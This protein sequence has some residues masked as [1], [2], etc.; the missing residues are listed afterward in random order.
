MREETFTA[1]FV[2]AGPDPSGAGVWK[3]SHF[4]F[5]VAAG[6]PPL[7]PCPLSPTLSAKGT[8]TWNA[9]PHFLPKYPVKPRQV[10][11][12]VYIHKPCS[13]HLSLL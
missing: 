10:E 6:L 1:V 5:M 8:S 9:M 3:F 12:S 2:P 7:H 13:S 4:Q 11:I